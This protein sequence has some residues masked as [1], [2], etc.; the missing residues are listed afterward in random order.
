MIFKVIVICL[1]IVGVSLLVIDISDRHSYVVSVPVIPSSISSPGIFSSKEIG[2]SSHT[3]KTGRVVILN[4]SNAQDVSYSELRKFLLEDQT[5][6]IVY[7]EDIFSCADYAELLQHNAENKNIHCAW[8]YVDLLN[9]IGHSLN[10]FRTVDQGLIF[11]DDSGVPMGIEHPFDMDKTV[12]MN[13]GS[14]YIP[15]S[16]FQESGWDNQ[17]KSGGIIMDYKIYWTGEL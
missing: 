6:K 1:L 10:A 7:K 8:V 12:I 14:S 9:S 16:L 15:E 5:D 2:Y 11:I 3:S 17:W 13:R 4:N